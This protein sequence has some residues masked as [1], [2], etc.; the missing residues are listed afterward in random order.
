M[1]ELA[2]DPSNVSS[3]TPDYLIPKMDQYATSDP[4][5]YRQLVIRDAG[6][7]PEGATELSGALDPFAPLP[8]QTAESPKEGVLLTATQNGYGKRTETT[9]YRKQ[10]RG[11]KGIMTITVTEKNG[12]VVGLSLATDEDVVML[13]TDQGQ[14]IRMHAKDISIIGRATQGVR[15]INLTK[16]EKLVSLAKIVPEPEEEGVE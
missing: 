8:A 4:V 7:P 9:E 14:L 13:I 10:S 5:Y 1:T 2:F 16:G 12:P 11:G 6:M 3:D 15:L